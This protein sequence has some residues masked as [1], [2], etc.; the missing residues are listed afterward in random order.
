MTVL[1]SPHLTDENNEASRGQVLLIVFGFPGS[2]Y[3]PEKHST[4]KDIINI[5]QGQ[6]MEWEKIF[7]ND[8]TGMKRTGGPRPGTEAHACNPSTLGGQA[9]P[10]GRGERF[11]Q[12]LLGAGELGA[13]LD[14]VASECAGDQEARRPE[15][16]SSKTSSQAGALRVETMEA[17]KAVTAMSSF[18]FQSAPL[19]AGSRLD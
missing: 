5:V 12:Q 1:L 10:S 18:A 3:Q 2:F 15:T 8:I 7:A 9:S 14:L 6:P 19:S 11:P 13:L 16:R 17:I 4:S